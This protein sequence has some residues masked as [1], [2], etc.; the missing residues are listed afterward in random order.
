MLPADDYRRLS[1][2]VQ[3]RSS[4]PRDS[5]TWDSPGVRAG[6]SLLFLS[7]ILNSREGL[8]LGI[9][10]QRIVAANTA[11]VVSGLALMLAFSTL[12]AAMMSA[13]GRE[14]SR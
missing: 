14:A 5:T 10:P 9:P 13:F 3:S 8:M 11:F 7:V 6:S 4:N 2:L 1:A 12:C